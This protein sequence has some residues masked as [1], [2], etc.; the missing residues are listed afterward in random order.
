MLTALS[1]L[2]PNVG[3]QRSS[4]RKL[5][6]SF[7]HS[8]LLKE[9]PVWKSVTQNKKTCQRFLKI[10]RQMVIRVTSSYRIISTKA[11]DVIGGIPLIDLQEIQR[12]RKYNGTSMRISSLN[13]KRGGIMEHMDDGP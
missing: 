1:M 3:D 12:A 6:N 13:G 10:Q 7:D 5:L 8:Q 9:A 2:M 11:V 4:K